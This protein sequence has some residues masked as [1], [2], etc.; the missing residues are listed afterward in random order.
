MAR[1]TLGDHNKIDW[2]RF[3]ND[4]QFI[5]STISQVIPALKDLEEKSG[6]EEGYYLENPLRN[7]VFKTTNSKAHFSNCPVEMVVPNEGELLLM[8]I[9]SHDQ[10]NTS[11]FGLND[12]CRGITNERH[13]LFMNKKDMVHLNISSEQ[14]VDLTSNYDDKL[15]KIE[16]YYA[17][18]YPIRQGCVAA[19]FPETNVL[20][21]VNNVSDI[22]QT[23]AYKSIR[24]KVQLSM[25]RVW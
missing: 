23:P 9:R 8:T 12:R 5:R 10:F 11:I 1:A 24:V 14:M 21:S 16:G 17:I 13:I 7:R 19:Y 22:C 4:Y 25:N 2:R 6:S 3:E 20:T 18:P 15:R